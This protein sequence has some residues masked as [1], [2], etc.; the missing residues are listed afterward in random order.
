MD[1]EEAGDLD[2]APNRGPT[3]SDNGTGP[4]RQCGREPDLRF[5]SDETGVRIA[6]VFPV[7][8]I[9]RLNGPFEHLRRTTSS[10]CKRCSQ[11]GV[12]R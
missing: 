6:F 4:V 12:A 9:Q 2:G 3:N 5:S 10:S 1:H 8:G 7:H 11:V